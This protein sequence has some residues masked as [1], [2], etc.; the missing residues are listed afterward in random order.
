MAKAA[1]AHQATFD[2]MDHHSQALLSHHQRFGAMHDEISEPLLDLEEEKAVP[3]GH[4]AG[5]LAHHEIAKVAVPSVHEPT[6]HYAPAIA[7]HPALDMAAAVPPHAAI[8]APVHH[9]EAELAAVAHYAADV[10]S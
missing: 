4:A 9:T 10:P 2:E 8:V 3:V 6:L 5:M 1:Y 7:S